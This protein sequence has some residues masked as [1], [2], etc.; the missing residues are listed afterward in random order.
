MVE[1]QE[2]LQNKL[3]PWNVVGFLDQFMEIHNDKTDSSFAFILG[4]GA[5]VNS[6]IDT[7]GS[8]AKILLEKL[9]RRSLVY[10]QKIALEEWAIADNLGVGFETFHYS[11]KEEF[12]PQL[13]DR[14]FSTYPEQGYAFLEKIIE[15]GKEPSFG[16]SVLARILVETR[17]K[18]VITTNFDNLVAEA[19]SI[20]ARSYPLVCDHESLTGFV[21]IR[22]RRPL[23]A[24]IH[25]DLLFAPI[26]DPDGTKKLKEGW[27][28]ALKML[29][30]NHIPIVIGYGGNDGSLMDLLKSMKTGEIPGGIY[31]CFRESD[32]HPK[33]DIEELVNQHPGALV[34]IDGFDEI[35][36]QLSNVLKYPLLDKELKQRGDTRVE[37]YKKQ[38]E[39]IV[40]KLTKQQKLFNTANIDDQNTG[41]QKAVIE[42]IKR[43]G[44]DYWWTWELR[45]REEID[46]DKKENIY[47]NGLENLKQSPKES[48]E[49]AGQFALFMKN[50]RQDDKKAEKLFKKALDL[51]P[52]NATNVGNYALFM[53]TVRQDNDEAE[54]MYKKAF[55]LN[56]YNAMHIYNFAGFMAKVRENQHRA[57]ELYQQA[58]KLDLFPGNLIG[59]LISL[60]RLAD[61]EEMAKRTWLLNNDGKAT[62]DKAEIAFYRGLLARINDRSDELALGRLRTMFNLGFERRSAWPF[63]DILDTVRPPKLS[64]DDFELYSALAISI[65]DASEHANLNLLSRWCEILPIS[66]NDSWEG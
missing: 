31:W 4:A 32:G 22:T 16:Y 30:R 11:R 65:V 56:P 33:K 21:R 50:V 27:E 8:L 64:K 52:N 19:L 49:L 26:N 54:I 43:Q 51:D 1:E 47:R 20:Y 61:A 28:A 39:S 46:P 66:L 55:E 29:L 14:C 15:K 17:H 2:T 42:T 45:V 12:Y 35:M 44:Q 59:E 3:I 18:V 37:N 10:N 24:K 58:K 7:A 62:E 36:L 34:G 23:I 25:R 48:A 60:D 13:F 40:D 57:D 9:H 5:S 38:F 6:G 63:V 41:F 53:E